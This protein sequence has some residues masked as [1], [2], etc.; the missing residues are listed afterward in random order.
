[1]EDSFLAKEGT[2]P[3]PYSNDLRV[4]VL[5][6]ADEGLSLKEVSQTFQISDKTLYLWRKQRERIGNLNPKSGYQKGH[7]HKIK[8]LEAFRQFVDQNPDRTLNEMSEDWGEV[9]RVTIHRYLKKIGHT[10]KKRAMGIM[11][12]MR[13]NARSL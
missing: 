4:R 8:D 3:Q 7:S 9:S 11:S 13:Q 6:K 10:R 12:V 2:M 5:A 1:M